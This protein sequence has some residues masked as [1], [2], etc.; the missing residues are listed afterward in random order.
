MERSK[1]HQTDV[2]SLT[3]KTPHPA[4][5]AM[6][7]VWED[8]STT[9]ETCLPLVLRY[10]LARVPDARVAEDLVGDVFERALRGWPS[11]QR[12]SLVNTWIL[13]IARHVIADYWRRNAAPPLRLELLP[14]ELPTISDLTLE[15]EAQRRD[16]EQRLKQ[17]ITQLSAQEQDMLALRY[18]T[19]LPEREIAVVLGVREGT[20]RVRIHRLKNRLRVILSEKEQ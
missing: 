1:S 5:G 2:L 7:N 12:R 17:A 9:Y 8:F 3:I 16:D 6:C 4:E 10:T 19:D 14:A 18:T 20:V 11:F 13:G 15:E